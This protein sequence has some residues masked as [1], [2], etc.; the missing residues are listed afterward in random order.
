MTSGS[1]SI[2]KRG[3]IVIIGGGPAGT[4]C[5][6]ALR[7]LAREISREIRITIVE[8]KQFTGEQHYNQCLGVLSPPLPALLEST[9]N[10]PFPHHLS[11]RTIKRYILHTEGEQITLDDD[12]QPSVAL[13][14]IQYD[15]Y[16]LE[17][18]KKRGIQVLPAR[19]VDLEFH[20]D[21]VVVYTENAP[22]E[23]Q[24][25]VGAFGLDEGSA[26]MFSRHTPY[27]A[28]RALSSIVT[29]I[30]PGTKKVDQFLMGIHA[31]LPAHPGIE[32]GGI[33]P[34]GNHL[35]I[36]I[37]GREVD[38]KLMD[39]FLQLPMVRS[40]VPFQH[41]SLDAHPDDFQLF[42][43]RFP[44]SLAPG[45]Y[46]DRYVTIGDA[47][48]LVRAFKGKGITSAVQTGIRAAETILTVGVSKQAFQDHYHAAN[49]DIIRDLPF[50][51]A[52]RLLT[53]T[54]ARFHLLDP[55]LRAARRDPSLRAALFDAV[56]AHAPYRHV[57]RRAL[58]P[59]TL[60]AIMRH[61]LPSRGN[62]GKVPKT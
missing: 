55:V 5:A 49:Q 48:G 24:V 57:V 40:T 30:R 44:C 28:P 15:T 52:V 20:R 9:L 14:R 39:T 50:G 26:G 62:R 11:Q 61:L 35:V 12:Q 42:K 16:M 22:L 51:R 19:A 17:A 1:D 25:V 18:V 4:A 31:F 37:A 43:G 53:I 3:H 10:L 34:K 59:R 54:L 36:N 29:K 8:G 38:V 23:A 45:Y 27:R 60:W 32:F 2:S 13:R 47:A 33:T 58:R 7:C 46:G 6:L 41:N 56:S 21:R